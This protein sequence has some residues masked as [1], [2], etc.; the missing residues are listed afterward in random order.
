M[1]FD[2]D[3]HEL[4]QATKAASR[5]PLENVKRQLEG[6]LERLERLVHEGEQRVV[7]M[8]RMVEH[9]RAQGRDSRTAED[10]L[11]TCED[12]L[13]Q[14]KVFLTTLRKYRTTPT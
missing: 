4:L 14:K 5:A 10:L 8:R 13:A 3:I 11:Q 12:L 1:P 7:R 9:Q 6:D 2:R